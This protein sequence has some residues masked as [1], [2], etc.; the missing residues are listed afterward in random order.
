MLRVLVPATPGTSPGL[1]AVTLLGQS[2]VLTEVAASTPLSDLDYT[3]VSYAWGRGRTAHPLDPTEQMSDRTIPAA[4]TA[5]AIAQPLALWLDALCVPA[6]EPQRRACLGAMGAIYAQAATV[7]VVL[8]NACSEL[9]EQVDGDQPVAA[10]ALLAFEADAWLTRAW[11]YQ[12]IVNGGHIRFV[13]EGGGAISIDAET[14]LNKVSQAID[15]YKAAQGYDSFEMKARH[16]RLDSLQDLVLDW[17]IAEYGE[18]SAYQ[19]MCG[20]LGREVVRPED[21][22]HAMIGALVT[23][24][25][26]QAR[27]PPAETFMR[28]CEAKGDYSFVYATA[29]R[30]VVRGRRW[31]PDSSV[32]RL[33]P[34][35]A[36]APYGSGQSGSVHPTHLQLDAMWQVTPGRHEEDAASYLAKWLEGADHTPTEPIADR[37]LRRL[38]QSGFTGC[39]ESLELATGYFFPFTPLPRTEAT[40]VVVATGVKVP[41]GAPGLVLARGA[42]DIHEFRDVGIFVG[43]VPKGG[44]SICVG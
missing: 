7:V 33:L 34:V 27:Q 43:Q 37:I 11:T 3:C 6:E 2:W 44:A 41:H 32:E 24:A 40:L 10:S 36:W 15:D 16:P 28:L 4:E 8:S 19:V 25:P 22:F 1:P 26:S 17:K 12:E 18:R 30:S 20:M 29:P 5:V 14:V 23:Q 39:G 21:Y 42:A 9:L 13:A 38:R 31:R 35:Y